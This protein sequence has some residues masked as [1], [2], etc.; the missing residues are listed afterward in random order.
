MCVWEGDVLSYITVC[1]GNDQQ[2]LRR[3]QDSLHMFAFLFPLQIPTYRVAHC[4]APLVAAS[5]CQGPWA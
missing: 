5:A 1:F 2:N 4:G 3:L